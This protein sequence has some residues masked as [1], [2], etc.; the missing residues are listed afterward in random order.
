M[1]LCLFSISFSH[2]NI[3]SFV[4]ISNTFLEFLPRLN[5]EHGKKVKGLG[6]KS[7]NRLP[8]NGGEIWLAFKW[9]L[10]FALRNHEVSFWFSLT[11]IF[12]YIFLLYRYSYQTLRARVAAKTEEKKLEL[13]F[14]R[15]SEHHKRLNNFI[16]LVPF[17]CTFMRHGSS[18]QIFWQSL[19]WLDLLFYLTL[20]HAMLCRLFLILVQKCPYSHF[21]ET[22][23]SFRSC[24]L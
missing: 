9:S 20:Y 17:N 3:Q 19:Q 11:T 6:R 4:I 14:L 18:W 15:W 10:F 1:L 24:A 23:I 5:K 2:A 7:V 21:I 13:L 12:I 8:R 22:K 16:R